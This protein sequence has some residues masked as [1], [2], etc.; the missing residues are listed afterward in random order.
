M[1]RPLRDRA[2]EY[3]HDEQA[4]GFALLAAAAIALLWVN[5]GG[6]SEYESLWTTELQ[7]G[8]GDFSI[9]EDLRHW[10]SD[11]LMAVFFFLISLEVKRE[12]LRGE[13]RHPKAAAL[14]ILAALGGVVVPVLVYL[15]VAGGGEPAEG[16]GIPMATDAA[17][18]IGV[19]AILGDRVPVGAKL[20]LVTLA[21]I[22]DI[23]AICVIALAF[24]SDLAPEWLA[25]AAIGLA[26]VAAL[27]RAGVVRWWVFIVPVVVVWVATFESGVHA[28]LAGVALALM[29]PAGPL[30]RRNVLEELEDRIHP[31]SSFVVLPLFALANAGIVLGGDTLDGADAQRVA[32]A[33]ALGLVVGKF[34][35]VAV[36]SIAAL[37]IGIG[38]L[39]EGVDLRSLLGLAALAGI[40]FTVSL[41]IAPLAFTEQALLDGAKTGVLAGSVLAAVIGVAVLAPGGRHAS[42]GGAKDRS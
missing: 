4:G 29:V 7:L 28:T 32:I 20:F 3:L 31:I 22:D 38:R 19:L 2:A 11:G 36:A 25:V 1:D 21:V 12:I 10:V 40:G 30:R 41:F 14:P 33:V 24:T 6:V 8:I 35:G 26:A 13:L 37:R 18:A 34:V 15:A 42:H 5:A 9:T 27:L 17:F 16:W 39:P 23:A